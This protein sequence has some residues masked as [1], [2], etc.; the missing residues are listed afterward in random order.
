MFVKRF[1]L[2]MFMNICNRTC[3]I[4]AIRKVSHYMPIDTI[5]SMGGWTSLVVSA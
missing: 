5:M 4:V 1:V 2:H 3:A